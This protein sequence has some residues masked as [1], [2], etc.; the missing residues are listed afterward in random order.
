MKVVA[1]H[2]PF[3]AHRVPAD[4]S[5]TSESP[6]NET[7]M[8]QNDKILLGYDKTTIQNLFRHNFNLDDC[9][10]TFQNNLY[11]G[12]Y[13]AS[14]QQYLQTI[15]QPVI[16]DQDTWKVRSVSAQL[17]MLKNMRFV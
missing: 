1:T 11:L 8:E 6:N 14:Y 5:E 16:E 4:V 9:I 2:P 17:Y 10:L 13:T 7:H 3:S 15:S 12:G